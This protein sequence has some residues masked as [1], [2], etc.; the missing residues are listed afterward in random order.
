MCWR[1]LDYLTDRG[2]NEIREWI[3]SLPVH[4]QAKIDHLL[5]VLSAWIR[6]G[7]LSMSVH[8]KGTK[9]STNSESLHLEYSIARLAVMALGRE[10][11]PS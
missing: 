2:E 1:I 6:S 4:A 5:L 7:R 8:S 11:T 3:N 10:N 9:I